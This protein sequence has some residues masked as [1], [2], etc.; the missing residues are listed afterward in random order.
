[1]PDNEPE[2]V[3]VRELLAQL[4]EELKA[5]SLYLKKYA[6]DCDKH[7]NKEMKEHLERISGRLEFIK[8]QLGGVSELHEQQAERFKELRAYAEE[9]K[10]S[11]EKLSSPPLQC[12]TVASVQ[13]DGTFDVVFSGR[14][15]RVCLGKDEVRPQLAVGTPVLLNEEMNI[16]GVGNEETRGEICVVD[17]VVDE[18][19]IRVVRNFDEKHVLELPSA[20]RGKK[21]AVGDELLCN[22]SS[23]MILERLEKSENKDLWLEEV[24]PV[25]Y[26]AIG[27]L[28]KQIDDIRKELEWPILHKELFEEHDRRPSKGVLLYGPPGCGK[29]LIAK[30]IAY[31]IA[32]EV[33][34]LHKKTKPEGFFINIKGPELLNKFVGETERRIREI[35]TRAKECATGERPALIFIDEADSLLKTRGSSISSDV[36]STVVP[37]FLSEMDGVEGLSNVV[38]ILASNRQDLI[39]PA[40]LRSG[41]IDLKVKVTRPDYDGAKEIFRIYLTRKQIPIHQKYTDRKRE[42]SW[43]PEYE[44]F[45]DRTDVME[46]LINGAMKRLWATDEEQYTYRNG[47]GKK[48]TVQNSILELTL[49]SGKKHLLYLKDFVSGA[50]I[51]N[52]VNRAKRNAIERLLTQGPGER[53]ILLRDLCVAI[54]QEMVEIEDLPNTGKDAQNWLEM[55]NIKEQVVHIQSLVEMRRKELK[56][57]KEVEEVRTGHYF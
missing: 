6:G 36:E 32:Q 28:A 42:S 51:E 47:S 57:Q 21:F 22:V 11:V 19:R 38:V 55:Q 1:M 49:H 2:N 12:A 13:K 25:E 43:K 8:R 7:R 16:I 3:G 50:M 17:S 54:E 10:A 35:F 5:H 56:E 41:R 33:A 46:Y 24:R 4:G 14:R 37:Q 52:I 23:G 27:G 20:L 9:L 15:T 48:I 44:K 40:V 34:R 31:H 45:K 53:G 30:A 26:S 18:A 39:D 29:T